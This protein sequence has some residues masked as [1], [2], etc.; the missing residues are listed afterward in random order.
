MKKIIYMLNCLSLL[1]LLSCRE[2][3][4]LSINNFP[5]GD[6]KTLPLPIDFGNLKDVYATIIEGSPDTNV[7]SI[8]LPKFELK[9]NIINGQVPL[10]ISYSKLKIPKLLE[11]LQTMMIGDTLGIGQLQKYT[12]TKEKILEYLNNGKVTASGVYSISG[13]NGGVGYQTARIILDKNLNN[14]NLL[15]ILIDSVAIKEKFNILT[16]RVSTT[17]DTSPNKLYDT[18]VGV[19]QSLYIEFRINHCCPSGRIFTD[20]GYENAGSIWRGS[21]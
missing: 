2:K 12:F 17:N 9:G 1:L 8:K 11:I 4:E 20:I 3:D 15:D 16:Y 19:Q 5:F 21:F 7:V 18:K 14:L 10:K 13:A 6:L